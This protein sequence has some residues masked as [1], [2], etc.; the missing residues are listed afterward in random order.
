MEST[1]T[2][3]SGKLELCVQVPDLR[4]SQDGHDLN[5]DGRPGIR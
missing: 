2:T 5:G 1:S 4:R 3:E